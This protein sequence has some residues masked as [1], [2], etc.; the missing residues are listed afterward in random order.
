MTHTLH[1]TN[2]K[3]CFVVV[4]NFIQNEQGIICSFL[5]RIQYLRNGQIGHLGCPYLMT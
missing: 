2:N 4:Y 5:A 1:Y 3:K